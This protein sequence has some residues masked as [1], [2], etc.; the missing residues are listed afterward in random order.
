MPEEA[1]LA[2][3]A[4]YP[5]KLAFKVAVAT[6]VH[7]V[8]RI[9]HISCICRLDFSHFRRVSVA[10]CFLITIRKKSRLVARKSCA[11]LLCVLD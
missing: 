7:E 8:R 10:V 2:K 9:Y 4:E 3:G 6:D 5:N 11:A 1:M